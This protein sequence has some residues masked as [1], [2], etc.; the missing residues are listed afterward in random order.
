[1]KEF[2]EY[3]DYFEKYLEKLTNQMVVDLRN[4]VKNKP[5]VYRDGKNETNIVG[6]FFEYDFE[7]FSISLYG[8]DK[9]LN[10]VTEVVSLPTKLIDESLKNYIIPKRIRDFGKNIEDTYD[11]EKY[12]E[13]EFYELLEEYNEKLREIFEKWFLKCWKKISEKQ[14]INIDAYFSVHDSYYY[15]DL[16]TMNEITENEILEKYRQSTKPKKLVYYI[17]N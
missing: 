3:L 11:K 6:C 8:L 2:K 13:D 7:Y 17:N 4:I 16:K 1:M 9:S 10:Q 12:S 5:F 14:K 15:T